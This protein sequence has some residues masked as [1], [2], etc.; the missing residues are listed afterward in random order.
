MDRERILTKLDELNN[1][2]KEIKEDYPNNY[3]EYLENKRKY[4][5][6]LHLSIEVVIDVSSLILKGRGSGVPADEDGIFDQLIQDKV[7]DREFGETLKEMKAFRNILV[8]RYGEI[9]D[10]KTYNQLNN[11]EDFKE[12]KK[13]VLSYLETKEKQNE[14]V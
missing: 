6:L 9:N 3:Q 14:K 4:E 2:L 11:L 5:R 1:Y 8:Y 12:F 13:Q 10:K 7:F